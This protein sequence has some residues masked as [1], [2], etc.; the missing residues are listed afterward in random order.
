MAT[1]ES[2][3][4]NAGGIALGWFVM[5]AGAIN[6]QCGDI[7]VRMS[8]FQVGMATDARVRGMDGCSQACFVNVERDG[9]AR[10]IGLGE[11]LV[12]VT[13]E[14]LLIADLL[15]ASWGKQQTRCRR[16]GCSPEHPFVTHMYVS[17][18][19]SSRAGLERSGQWVKREAMA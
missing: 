12:A 9:F 18:M 5:A 6:R 1:F 3:S 11:I 17:V 7:V 8:C 16:Q 14:A 10:R 4:V 13:F 15:G 19:R 2:Q